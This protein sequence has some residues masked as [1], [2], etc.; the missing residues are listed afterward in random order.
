MRN[1]ESKRQGGGSCV[2]D[3]AAVNRFQ[4]LTVSAANTVTAIPVK[5]SISTISS[6]Y[7]AV[8][9]INRATYATVD[10]EETAT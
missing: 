10:R 9:P 7:T 8:G 1:P 6:C 3:K 5:V 2:Q 4:Y